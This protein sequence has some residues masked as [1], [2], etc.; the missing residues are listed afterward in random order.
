MDILGISAF[1]HDS[2]AALVRDGIPIAAAQEERFSR[3]K[4]DPSFPNLA[5][6]YCLNEGGIS[7]NELD[8]VVFYEKPLRKFERILLTHLNYFPRSAKAFSKSMFLWLGDRL[9]MKNR[10]AE[11]LGIAPSKILFTEHHQSHAAST[12]FPSPFHEAA[13]LIVDGVG[14]WAT[15]TLSKGKG[16]NLELL[17]EIHFLILWDFY[18]LQ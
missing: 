3:I 9:W 2:A 18:I 1:Y 8:W 7:V 6:N 15:T 11:E 13:I 10:I 4:N 5:I 17:E 16:N 12:F 14:E